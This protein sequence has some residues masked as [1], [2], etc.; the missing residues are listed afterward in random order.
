MLTRC[1]LFTLVIINPVLV[2]ALTD[3]QL[4]PIVV[5]ATREEKLVNEVPHAISVARSPDINRV[6]PAHPS[7]LMNRFP[8]V[9]VNDLGGEG[10]MTAIRQPIT[11][12]GVYLFLEDGIPIR[13]TGLFNHN[14]LYEINLPQSDRVEINKGLAPHCMAVNP[15]AVLLIR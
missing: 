5:T 9:H 11:T 8:G 12:S 1:L 10:H 3:N 2:D 14:A 7:E 15:L 6:S 4:P 13:P